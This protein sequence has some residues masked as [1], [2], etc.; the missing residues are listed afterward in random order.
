MLKWKQK[1]LSSNRQFMQI[2][3]RDTSRFAD[4]PDAP[5]LPAWTRFDYP[6]TS[7]AG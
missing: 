4:D 3:R 5:G 2:C 1:V 7:A 6:T